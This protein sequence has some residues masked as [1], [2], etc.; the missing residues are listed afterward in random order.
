[1]DYKVRSKM[2]GGFALI[3]FPASY[4]VS[5]VMTFIVNHQGVVYEKDLGPR[6]AIRA[7]LITTFNPDNTWRPAARSTEAAR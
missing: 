2:I 6:T 3:A 1:M 5:G 7:P 4:G